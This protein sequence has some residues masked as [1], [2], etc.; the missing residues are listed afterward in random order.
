MSAPALVDANVLVAAVAAE[1][2]H[3]SPSLN[4][5]A[6]MHRVRFAVAAHSF[7]E[8]YDTLTRDGKNGPFQFPP[9]EALAVLEDLRSRVD[10]LG[11]TPLQT[12]DGI[13]RYALGGGIGPRLYDKLIG[14]IAV[15]HGITSI[16]TWNLKHMGGLFASVAVQTPTEFMASNR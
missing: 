11:S 8:A 7:A 9:D 6:L 10:L 16:V 2:E 12:F 13:R 1:H 3:H 4:F 15:L 14:D 5:A